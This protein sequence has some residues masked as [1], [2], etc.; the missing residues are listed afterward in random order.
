MTCCPFCKRALFTVA[1]VGAL[2]CAEHGLIFSNTQDGPEP[3]GV[4]QATVVRPLPAITTTG[5]TVPRFVSNQFFYEEP[6]ASAVWASIQATRNRSFLLIVNGA[7]RAVMD[8]GTAAATKS[9]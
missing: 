1:A 9:G 7:H 6:N 3:E 4:T 8:Q 5:G 2:A